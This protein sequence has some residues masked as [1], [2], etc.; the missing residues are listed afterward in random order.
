MNYNDAKRKVIIKFMCGALVSLLSAIS[1]IISILKMF[2][3]KLD[4]GTRFGSAL[5]EI[6]KRITIFTYEHTTFLEFFWKHSPIVN[7]FDFLE[8]QSIQFF[9]IYILFFIAWAVI[10]SAFDLRN[11][12]KI[13]D[14]QIED[15]IIKESIKGSNINRKQVENNVSISLSSKIHDLYIAPLLVAIIGAIIIKLL[16]FGS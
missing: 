12:L 14:K 2:Y 3:F 7:P 4:D 9:I 11:R 15:Q 16:G 10:R 13:I 8:K 5:S 1:T 6:F